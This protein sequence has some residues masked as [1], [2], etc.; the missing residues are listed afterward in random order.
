MAPEIIKTV[1]LES[2]MGQSVANYSQAVDLYSP[3]YLQSDYAQDQ[4]ASQ[5][6]EIYAFSEFL[7]D[8][9]DF[10][11]RNFC[12]DFLSR[13]NSHT[14][15]GFGII[16]YEVLELKAPWDEPRFKK[17]SHRLIEAVEK[18]ERP[19]FSVENARQAPP[20]YVE[21]MQQCWA[22]APIE[23]PDFSAVL[24]Q[25]QDMRRDALA[26]ATAKRSSSR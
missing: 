16:L 21:L 18:G 11:R 8:T 5:P 24:Y 7:L 26:N 13:Y 14:K 4:Y 12:F 3:S 20:G 22:Q 23:R 1:G 10:L 2:R 25:L 9:R 6:S 19:K 17:Y 15:T